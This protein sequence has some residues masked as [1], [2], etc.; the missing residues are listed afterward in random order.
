MKTIFILDES[1]D[2]QNQMNHYLTAMGFQV[3]SLSA[4]EFD[5]VSQKPLAIILDEEFRSVEKN[6]GLLLLKKIAR[7]MSGVPVVF[8]KEGVDDTTMAEAKKSGAYEVIEKNSAEFVNLR[9]ALD[10]IVNDPPKSGWFA[11]LFGKKQT[12]GM[13]ALSV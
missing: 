13:P 2:R 9:T 1:T 5:N 4:I 10:K 11:R 12:P 6:G 7:K 3:Q 8:M